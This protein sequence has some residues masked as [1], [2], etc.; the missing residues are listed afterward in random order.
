MAMVPD[1]RRA[2][3]V[4][5]LSSE[6]GR[7]AS[8]EIVDTPGISRSHEGNAARLG[9]IREAAC[10]LQVVASFDGSDPAR[11]LQGFEEDLLLADLDIVAGRVER[12]RESLKKPRPNRD[13]Q[14]A[15]LE[16]IEPLLA[17]LEAGRLL[18]DMTLSEEQLK[19]T[20]SF[21]LLTPKRR[22]A[23]VNAPTM[24]RNC[25]ITRPSGPPNIPLSPCLSVWK[26]NCRG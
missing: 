4:R 21:Q 25:R 22:M 18:T 26:S 8:L 9:L 19:A 12:L 16:A 6:E 1:Q 3:F 20:R 15:E 24:T 13:E 14:Q 7:E 10:L 2:G 23:I 17:T 11:D 5:G